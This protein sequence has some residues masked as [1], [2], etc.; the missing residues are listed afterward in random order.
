MESANW[1]SSCELV[2]SSA[3]QTETSTTVGTIDTIECTSLD[4]CAQEI[5]NPCW[6]SFN[7]DT[8]AGGTVWPID[9]DYAC[10][11]FSSRNDKNG[12]LVEGQGRFRV[13]CQCVRGHQLHM[14]GE[15][16]S[17]HKPLSSAGDVTDKGHAL[18][19]D[20][21]VGYIIQKRFTDSD[22]DTHVFRESLCATLVEW[23]R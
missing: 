16:T 5:A 4:L 15:K 22:S 1:K 8:G 13:R 6:I 9:A 23:S 14:T 10:E 11:K 3:P 18:W 17:V 2:A 19:L 20:G 7:V 12:E 21:D